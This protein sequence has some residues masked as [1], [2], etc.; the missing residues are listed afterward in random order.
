MLQ[1]SLIEKYGWATAL[2]LL[3]RPYNKERPVCAKS[4]V[5]TEKELSIMHSLV[6]SGDDHA[7]ILRMMGVGI[8]VTA[9]RYWWMEFD[10]YA[11]GKFDLDEEHISE[12]TMH[13]KATSPFTS[14]DFEEDGDNLAKHMNSVLEQYREVPSLLT[15]IKAHLPEGFLQ[16]REVLLNYQA[17]R[18][19][20]NGRKNHRLPQWKQFCEWISTLPYATALI[21]DDLWIADQQQAWGVPR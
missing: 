14:L 7:K 1:I 12:S 2:I 4:D 6:M 9:P 20:Y 19:I 17:L 21:C 3:R 11:L 5:P 13:R 18:H 8:T 16:T 15:Q 10:T